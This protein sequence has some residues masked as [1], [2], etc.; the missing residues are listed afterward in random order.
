MVAQ[1]ETQFGR[2]LK[3][4]RILTE[5]TR[6]GV[7]AFSLYSDVNVRDA[8]SDWLKNQS[9]V[10]VEMVR[11]ASGVV[12]LAE[13]IGRFPPS[14][15]HCFLF[16]DIE[17]AFPKV[18]GYVNLHRERLLQFGHA[19]VFWI[20]EEGLRRIAESA[21]DFWAWRSSVF[22][23]RTAQDLSLG[24]IGSHDA[25]VGHYDKAQLLEQIQSLEESGGS[26][27]VTQLALGRRQ[28]ALGRFEEADH[29]L[30]QSIAEAERQSDKPGLAE[31][32]VLL[33]N[34][35]AG[36]GLLGEANKLYNLSFDIAKQ[37][38]LKEM[39]VTLSHRFS[40][41]AQ[42]AGDADG[43]YNL[44]R[45]AMDLAEA[46]GDKSALASAHQQ[47]GNV[48]FARR[49]LRGAEEEYLAAA[50][51]EE[52]LS[53][54]IDLGRILARLSRVYEEMGTA[55]EAESS[56]QR[57]VELLTESGFEPPEIKSVLQRSGVEYPKNV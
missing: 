35:K 37:I 56:R 50:K 10:P 20:R 23:F 15:R 33:A 29:A 19:L 2:E 7:L 34:S 24:P 40:E 13:I 42:L 47:L 4:L 18:L 14:S 32:L 54:R 28:L 45:S 53:H 43:A 16:F 27:F 31:A 55:S 26:D 11:L 41:L 21:P 38:G 51:Y 6:E 25:V 49:D 46:S 22:D 3:G 44:A 52:Q 12:D 57:A 5:Q 1:V 8:A 9:S 36:Q 30:R 39:A 17:A 48:L